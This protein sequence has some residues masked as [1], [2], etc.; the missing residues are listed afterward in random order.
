LNRFGD[1]EGCNVFRAGEV[2]GDGAA[3]F[4]QAAVGAGAQT[5]FV[6]GCFQQ[7]LRTSFTAEKKRRQSTFLFLF[8]VVLL[9][10]DSLPNQA[11][12]L[13]EKPAQLSRKGFR[14]GR[15]ATLRLAQLQLVV[16]AGS[17]MELGRQ[18]ENLFSARLHRE[19][20]CAGEYRIDPPICPHL[21]K[22][23]SDG[24]KSKVFSF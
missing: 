18:T 14:D 16:E 7:L 15:S 5:E 12:P 20:S 3:H 21:S 24:R 17:E 6:D 8:S 19:L 13:H 23:V 10:L 9:V 2:V 4:Q 1:M 22:F 11:A